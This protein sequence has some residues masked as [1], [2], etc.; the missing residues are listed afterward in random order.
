MSANRYSKR[1]GSR[2]I[3]NFLVKREVWVTKATA[4]ALDR[5][6]LD[7]NIS[8]RM[9]D[10]VVA[11][12]YVNDIPDLYDF[13]RDIYPTPVI[14]PSEDVISK[15]ILATL[16]KGLLWYDLVMIGIDYG[17]T[18]DEINSSINGLMNKG[19]INLENTNDG[20]LFKF[21]K[22]GNVKTTQRVRSHRGEVVTDE[23]KNKK[24]IVQKMIAKSV[25]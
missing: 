1:Q 3:P 19:M 10:S 6:A 14:L 9:H 12:S 25:R 23:R 4:D 15:L 8:P 13:T 11:F 22:Y 20:P 16:K 18:Q 21:V 24:K 17:L 2:K 5:K 7:H